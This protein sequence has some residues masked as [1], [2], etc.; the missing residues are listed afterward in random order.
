MSITVLNIISISIVLFGI[1]LILKSQI[2]SLKLK[3][4]YL[5][6]PLVHYAGEKQLTNRPVFIVMFGVVLI[7]VGILGYISNA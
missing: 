2:V 6:Y 4:F 7:I 5:K 3:E 1:F